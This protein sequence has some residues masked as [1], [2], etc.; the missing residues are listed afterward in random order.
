VSAANRAAIVKEW[1]AM[2]T[3]GLSADEAKR[4]A[5]ANLEKAE[6]KRQ[7]AQRGLDAQRAAQVAVTEKT[8]R[9]RALRLAKEAAD[10]EA[11]AIAEAARPKTVASKRTKRA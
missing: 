7:E 10:A 1:T 8:A 11:A 3:K 4:R 6:Q 2:S 5:Q 9:L